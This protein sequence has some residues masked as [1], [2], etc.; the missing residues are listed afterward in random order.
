MYC[1]LLYSGYG[2]VWTLRCMVL[3]RMHLRDVAAGILPA[4]Q[5]MM[6]L[7][8]T[9]DDEITLLSRG[10]PDQSGE[11]KWFARACAA[12]T[13]ATLCRALRYN[14]PVQLLCMDLCLAKA[15]NRC[16]T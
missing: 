3:R 5:C 15:V 16:C 2:V 14:H 1:V 10:F 13:V 6:P 4:G 12:K 9:R 8:F 7:R 11:L